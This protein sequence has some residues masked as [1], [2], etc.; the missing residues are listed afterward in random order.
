[1]LVR[2]KDGSMRWCIDYRAH[3]EKTV[4]DCYPLP[5]IEDCLDTLQG[6]KYFATLDM[7]S[8]YY[9]IMIDKSDRHK[10]AFITRYGLFEHTRMG[11]GL[12]NAPA[13]FLRA[14]QLILTGL[15]WTKV[16]VYLD[17]V[18]VLGSDFVS[19][20]RNLR[21]AFDRFRHLNLKLKPKKCALFQ[22][23][24]EFLGKIVSSRG[25][26]I[27]PTKL[28]SVKNWPVPTNPTELLSFLRFLNFHRGHRTMLTCVHPCM[29][30]LM[31]RAFGHGTPVIRRR[32]N[33][34]RWPYVQHL[35]CHT[36][37]L[38][39]FSSWT[40]MPQLGPLGQFY[41]K[42][43]KA[44]RKLYAMQVTCSSNPSANFALLEKSY[45]L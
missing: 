2:K 24:V 1:M 32:L 11:M 29:S 12:C 42:S 45:W 10:T 15:T 20:L 21:E 14:M 3:N 7:A 27:S 6:T 28:E 39:D 31:L 9:Q 43:R 19:S 38:M 13:N 23:E 25:I 18:V 5:I 8:S 41:H 36:Q 37:I 40:L 44:R 34:L 33:K 30:W 26:S 17:D 35:A 22:K 4:K 16:L